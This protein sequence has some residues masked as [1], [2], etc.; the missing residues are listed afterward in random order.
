MLGEALCEFLNE[1]KPRACKPLKSRGPLTDMYNMR[2]FSQQCE[3][4]GVTIPP[5]QINIHTIKQSLVPLFAFYTTGDPSSK[6][7]EK[8]A[9]IR[10]DDSKFVDLQLVL[11]AVLQRLER[12]ETG[13]G[14]LPS[15][16]TVNMESL[17]DFG[18]K[19]EIPSQQKLALDEFIKTEKDYCNDLVAFDRVYLT[20]LKNRHLLHP[21]V[22]NDLEL[23]IKNLIEFSESLTVLVTERKNLECLGEIDSES[24]ELFKEYAASFTEVSR[25]LDVLKNKSEHN[26]FFEIWRKPEARGQTVESYLIKPIQRLCK[27]PLLLKEYAKDLPDSK[28]IFE[29]IDTLEAFISKVNDIATSATDDKKKYSIQAKLKESVIFINLGHIQRRREDFV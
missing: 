24:Y 11:E 12:L 3:E 20:E 5:S 27:Y 6:L 9:S 19:N 29:V 15:N 21:N 26:D 10:K 4:L 2:A 22:A 18:Q 7:D 28:S 1:I 23:Y 25:V 8:I 17:E 13:L 14:K 16:I